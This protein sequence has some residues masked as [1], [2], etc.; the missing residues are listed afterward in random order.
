LNVQRYRDVDPEAHCRAI[1]PPPSP[2]FSERYCMV[3]CRKD[4]YTIPGS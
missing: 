2:H 1:H 3:P 4:L